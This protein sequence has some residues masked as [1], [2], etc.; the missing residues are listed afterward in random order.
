MLQGSTHRDCILDQFT[1]QAVA[2][3]HTHRSAHDALALL[4]KQCGVRDDDQVLDVACGP[5]VVSCAIARHARHVTGIDI[6][7][8]MLDQAAKL[9]AEQGLTNLS[10]L[11]GD[12]NRLP[13]PDGS[14]SLVVSRYAL[15]HCE[16]P[17]RVIAEMARVCKPD[18]RV[19]V[20][21]SAPERVRA[22]GFN[23]AERMRDPS[24]TRALTPDELDDAM[25]AAG[26]R[27]SESMLYAWEVS[28][29]GLL[30]R[31][32]PHPGDAQKLMRL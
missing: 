29:D 4:V 24:H 2:F 17:R 3:Q 15:H 14:F 9:Q 6:T 10:W 1:Q 31:S 28:A 13:I 32:F 21:D 26:L 8:A 16:D 25:R 18:G 19:V 11:L 12:V 23:A 30:A 27:V 20:A 7:P 5:G 22:E